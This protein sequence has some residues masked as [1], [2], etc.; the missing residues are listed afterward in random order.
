MGVAPVKLANLS[1]A[2]W[3][4]GREEMAHTSAGFSIATMARAASRSFSQVFFRS[5]RWTPGARQQRRYVIGQR[6]RDRS[7]QCGKHTSQRHIPGIV[8]AS[9]RRQMPRD[10]A[11]CLADSV[12]VGRCMQ[13]EQTF[14]ASFRHLS[15]FSPWRRSSSSASCAARTVTLLRQT[16]NGCN[17]SRLYPSNRVETILTA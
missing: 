5:I 7:L 3:P 17:V 10:G 8:T 6:S 1:T 12:P 11:T 14:A 13:H 9:H 4:W 2:R 15:H 16:P